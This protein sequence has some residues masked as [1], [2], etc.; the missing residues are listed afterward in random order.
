MFLKKYISL[1]SRHSAEAYELKILRKII[2]KPAQNWEN[3]RRVL[4]A[5][6]ISL[7]RQSELKLRANQQFLLVDNDAQCIG[8]DFL[9]TVCMFHGF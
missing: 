3:S 5:L 2:Q 6:E 7:M 1:N 9:I 4:S 8:D